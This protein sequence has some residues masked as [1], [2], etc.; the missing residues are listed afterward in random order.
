MTKARICVIGSLNMDLVVQTP[1]LPAPGQTILGGPFQ[2][3]PGG[4]GANQA[5]AAAR[6]GAQVTMIGCVGSDSYGTMLRTAL[7][8][9]GIDTSHVQARQDMASGVALIAVA[10][11]GQNTIIVAP[12]AN[13]TLTPAD[14][15]RYEETIRAS[16]VVLLQLEIPLPA[17]ER[18]IMLA[19]TAGVQVILNPAPAQS[20][21]DALLRHVDFLVPNETEAATLTGITPDSWSTA[22]DA[23]RILAAKG[24]GH[25]V[26]TLGSRGALLFQDEHVVQ[27]PAFP[28]QAIDATAAGDAFVGAFGVA[29]ADGK[30]PQDALRW[31][32]AAGAIAATQ[33]GAQPSLPSRVAIEE[34]I[35]TATPT[36]G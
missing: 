2:T 14:I 23:A 15:D 10:P 30:S 36:E 19:S 28:V 22:A 6:A 8:A 1:H 29:L 27:Q 35:A 18:A 31:G 3:I 26:I 12:G 34:C 13:A 20:L 24:V 33:I 11:D 5:V 4:K 32:A 25:T 17:V 21:P 16:Q 7:E 9:E